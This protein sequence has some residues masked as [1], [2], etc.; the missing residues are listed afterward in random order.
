MEV[1]KET[2]NTGS[3]MKGDYSQS[4]LPIILANTGK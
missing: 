1:I 2:Q 4:Y 3:I